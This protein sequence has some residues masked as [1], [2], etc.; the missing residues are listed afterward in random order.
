MEQEQ[1]PE[2]QHQWELLDWGMAF[3]ALQRCEVCGE[4]RKLSED[5]TEAML[6]PYMVMRLRADALAG[7]ERDLLIRWIGRLIQRRK[8]L[9]GRSR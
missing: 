3:Q 7:T 8:D 5:E 2:H 4:A 6:F 1:Q 9:E